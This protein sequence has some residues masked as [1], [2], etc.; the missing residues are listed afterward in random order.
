V[1]AEHGGLRIF[2]TDLCA[3]DSLLAA[4]F[5]RDPERFFAASVVVGLR[6]VEVVDAAVERSGD[7]VVGVVLLLLAPVI[8][9]AAAERPAANTE[10][11]DLDA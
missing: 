11:G 2:G 10:H 8:L 9:F 7:Y 1:L 6:G 4:A 5:E 3:D